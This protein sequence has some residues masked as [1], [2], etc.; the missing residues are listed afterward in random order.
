MS[1]LL[2]PPAELAAI[3]RDSSGGAWLTALGAVATAELVAESTGADARIKWPNDVRVGGRKIAGVLVER[4]IRPRD[5]SAPPSSP[6]EPET[7]A[8]VGVGLNVNLGVDDL[9]PELRDRATS[10]QI[11]AGGGSFDRSELVRDLIRRLDRWYDQGVREGPASLG[12]AWRGLSEHL[13]RRVRVTTPIQVVEGRLVDLDLRRGLTL[14]Q[15]ECRVQVP[16]GSVV[17]LE[18]GRSFR[19]TCEPGTAGGG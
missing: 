3:G 14:D 13:G 15:G 5:H 6:S 17:S 8:V 19:P 4:V 11:L 16:I 7:A 9:D 18:D 10:L 2:F 1:V 12:A